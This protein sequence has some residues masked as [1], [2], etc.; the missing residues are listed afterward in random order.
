[1]T[2]IK[3]VIKGNIEL[4]LI[5]LGTYGLHGE[6]LRQIM[7]TALVEGYTLFDT[8]FKYQNE[9]E[10]GDILNSFCVDKKSLILESK[11][12]H[13]QLVGNLRFL[14]LNRETVFSAYKHSCKRLGVYDCSIFLLHSAFDNYE[15]YF[16][17]LLE[18]K[19]KNSLIV[20]ICNVNKEKILQLKNKV[21]CFPDIIQVEIHP[22]YSNKELIDFCYSNDI[23]VEARS[24][25]AHGDAMNEWLKDGKMTSIAKEYNKTIPQIILRWLVQQE[26]IPLPKSTNPTHVKDNIN[27]FDFSLSE[28]QMSLID[29][30]N[31]NKSFGALSSIC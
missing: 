11:V 6:I 20:G 24:P 28:K 27:I 22:Y 29:G 26:I 2:K 30:M 3:H 23:I 16:M 7:Q 5:G 4:P 13:P 12:C 14:R 21:G 18:M 19:Q 10:I 17:D 15:K 9:S 25:F 1:M 31:K 8:A